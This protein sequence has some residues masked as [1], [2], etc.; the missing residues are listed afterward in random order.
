M[1][2]NVSYCKPCHLGQNGHNNT[3]IWITAVLTLKMYFLFQELSGTFITPETLDAAIDYA[4]ANPIDYNFAIDLK[5]NKY[6]GRDTPIKEDK[7]PKTA[8]ATA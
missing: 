1:S 7:E 2:I 4:L 5:G 8:Q 3:A 6:Y